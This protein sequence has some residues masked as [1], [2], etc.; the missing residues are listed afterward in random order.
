MRN[1]LTGS[2]L[3]NAYQFE[4]DFYHICYK[5]SFDDKVDRHIYW[6]PLFSAAVFFFKFYSLIEN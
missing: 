2:I 6:G 4:R 5:T 3:G 1:G